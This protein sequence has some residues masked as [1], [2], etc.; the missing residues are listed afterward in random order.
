M[1]HVPPL[2]DI[3]TDTN[4]MAVPNETEIITNLI[5]GAR[6]VVCKFPWQVGHES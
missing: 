2:H 5:A 1:F 4:L 3:S 6:P